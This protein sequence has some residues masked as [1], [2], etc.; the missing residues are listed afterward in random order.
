VTS[1]LKFFRACLLVICLVFCGQSYGQTTFVKHFST[2]DGLP[3][4]SCY[5]ILQDKKGYIWVA[6]DAGVC[7][8]DGKVFET[9]TI[10]DGLPDN[11]IIK[12]HEDRRG[13]I[14][15]SALNGQLSYFYN[16]RIFNEK[17]DRSVRLLNFK[18]IIISFFEDSRGTMWFGTNKNMLVQWDGKSIKKYVS[19]DPSSQFISAVVYE[20]SEGHIWASSVNC[21]HVFNGNTFTK[22]AQGS[23]LLSFKTALARPDHTLLFLDSKGLNV[24]NGAKQRLILKI[25]SALL[26]NNPGYFYA[27][28]KQEL[29]LSNN[30]GVYYVDRHGHQIQYLSNVLTYQIIKDSKDNMWFGTNNG[31]YML[32]KK[33]KRIYVVDQTHGLSNNGIKSLMKDRSNRLWL[34]MDNGTINILSRPGYTVSCVNLPAN[35][36]S[37][38]KQLAMDSSGRT[39]YFSSDYS[40]G[41]LNYTDKTPEN[42]VYLRETNNVN[43][44]LKNFSI[45]G[46]NKLALA[47]SSGIVIIDNPV[48]DF[49]FSSLA[50]KEGKNFFSSRAYRVFYDRHKN[51]WFSNASGYSRFGGGKITHVHDKDQLLSKRINAMAEL[52]DG[53]LVLATDGYGLLFYRNNR[54]IRHITREN[55][56]A[57]NICKK[58]F[59]Q[60]DYL[61]VVTN[62]AVNRVLLRDDYPVESF[63]F[64]NSLLDNDVNEL[65]VD[66]DTAYFATNHG[67]VY[68]ANSPFDRTREVPKVMISAIQNNKKPLSLN[69]SFKLAAADNNITFYYSA[70]DFQNNTILYR[71]RLNPGD[72]WTET[73][74]RRLEFSSLEPDHYTFELSA[75]TNNSQW[76]KP[77]SVSF[78]LKVAMVHDP[79]AAARQ[80]RY[81]PD[82]GRGNQAAERQGPAAAFIKKQDTDA[83][84]A[85]FTG[86]DEPAFRIQCYE[87]HTALYQYKEHL[88]GQQDPHRICKADQKKPGYLY[89]KFYFTGRGN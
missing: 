76:S 72:N 30:S 32:P 68:F 5:H 12:L 42:P 19:A 36:F 22:V 28:D 67:L 23:A 1:N 6:T 49:S 82:R 27:E 17:N 18:T 50:Y 41:K 13:R 40:L 89:Q 81:L 58:L 60:K 20:D 2:R 14:W 56:L 87:F 46:D 74:S 86:H 53:T 47:L 69:S 83:G 75:R 64:T 8:F 71:Y 77:V 29:W 85:G 25:D 70:I 35:K 33:S 51:L 21:L 37:P 31:I 73:R 57:G 52:P 24:R 39:V 38:I 16:G 34:G 26:N 63:D 62:N 3:S 44:V 55:G 7:R 45:S 11:Q 78:M 48:Q 65:Y 84:T 43:I 54:I 4:N 61:W 88:L 15:F 66:R 59:V 79:A 80:F 10:D 9:F